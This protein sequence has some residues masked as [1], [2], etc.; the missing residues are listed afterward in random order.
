MVTNSLNTN[1]TPLDTRQMK[2]SAVYSTRLRET[3][4]HLRRLE[5]QK[6]DEALSKAAK[7]DKDLAPYIELQRTLL[8]LQEEAR[9]N[10]P[11]V[12]DAPDGQAL[13]QR[14]AEGKPVLEFAHLGLE[15]ERFARL[16]S[17]VSQAL[18][19]GEV[20]LADAAPPDS[21]AEWL[22][23]AESRFATKTL[24]GAERGEAADTTLAEAAADLA[25]RPYLEWAAAQLLDSIDLAAWKHGSCPICGGEPD[26]AS[27]D[28]ESGAR[29]L[30]CSRCTTEW[31]YR[32]V[33]CPFCGTSDHTKIS[34]HPS[35]DGA[36]RLYVCE[37][38]KRYLK[39][40]DLRQVN[41]EVLLPVE[42]VT[43]LALDV[44]ARQKGYS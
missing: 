10:L 24:A 8:Q 23:L 16:A 41:H 27:L 13:G 11:A 9:K 42:R 36:Y 43:S 2:P 28:T 34:Y 5:L 1:G 40:I 38:C 31:T 44:A 29:R 25:L 30:L 17:R 6:M 18:R 32:R 15:A 37:E 14:L 20:E 22:A 4:F 7:K 39:T 35:E 3:T 33:G 19:D 21:D 26:F 12:L